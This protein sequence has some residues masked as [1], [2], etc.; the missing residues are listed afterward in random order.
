MEPCSIDGVRFGDNRRI[1]KNEN[2][3]KN[4]NKCQAKKKKQKRN[5]RTYQ[6]KNKQN[7]RKKRKL[8][9]QIMTERTLIPTKLSLLQRGRFNS[10]YGDMRVHNHSSKAHKRVLTSVIAFHSSFANI[11]ALS[12]SLSLSLS[13]CQA[14]FLYPSLQHLLHHSFLLTYL[15][16]LR[17]P[18]LSSISPCLATTNR[19]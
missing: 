2:E 11:F 9:S 13:L 15:S 1:G 12:L 8:K 10:T 19:K 4:K 16:S 18:L 17:C 7:K 5:R 6:K 14:H 3:Y